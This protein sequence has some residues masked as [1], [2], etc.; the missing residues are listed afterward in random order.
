MRTSIPV[1]AALLAALVIVGTSGLARAESPRN[2]M[3]EIK[4]GPFRPGVDKEFSSKRPWQ[5]VFGS[6][7]N[8]MTQIEFDYEILKKVGTL[9]VGGAIGYSLAKGNGLLRDGTKS[10]DKSKFNTVPLSASLI[11]R[12]DYLAQRFKI[13]LVPTFKA[14]IDCYVWWTTNGQGKISKSSDGLTGRGATFGG[15]ASL[16]LMLLLDFMAPMMAQ[17]FDAELG[18]NNTYLFF[19]YTW[20]WIN[21]FGSGK[22]I[23][24]SNDN[25]LAG[26]A[27][28]F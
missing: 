21:D 10:T 22:S 20:S 13:P 27:F 5:S 25:V 11:Y 4:F 6:G 14:G 15:H 2:F 8:L 17:T 23:I 3:V 1:P 12:F 19:E 24:L 26:L 9:A 16:G 7:Y 18:V 28:E